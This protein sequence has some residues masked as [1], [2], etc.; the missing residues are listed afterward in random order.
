PNSHVTP[1][2]LGLPGTLPVVNRSAVEYAIRI[3]LALGCDIAESCRFARK[4]YIYPDIPKNFQTSQFDEPIAF[5]GVVDIEREDGT[6]VAVDVVRAHM[7]EDA[8]KNTH[9]ATGGRCSRLQGAEYSL[10][11]YNRAG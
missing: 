8:G 6:V 9:K 3:G 11:D 7:E 4:N 5:D 10:V 2:S 1:V